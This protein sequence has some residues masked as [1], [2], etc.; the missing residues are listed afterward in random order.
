MSKVIN[1]KTG[2]IGAAAV[3]I[4]IAA[5]V[6][7][8]SFSSAMTLD[9]AK[10]IAKKHVPQTAEFVTSE[11]EDNKYE[12]MFHDNAAK[13]GYEVEVL[14]ETKEVRK[15]ETQLD[16]DSGSKEV[17]LTEADI[18]K[19]IKEKFNGADNVKVSLSKDNGLYEYEASFKGAE[20]YG[21]ADVHPVNG[22]I[23]ESTLKFGTAVTIPTGD[24][25][26]DTAE[27]GM[28][29]EEQAKEAAI[30]AAAGGFVKDIELEKENGKYV[31]DVELIKDN[32]EYDYYIDASTGEV[33]LEFEHDSYFDYDDDDKDDWDEDNDGDGEDD[34]R[35]IAST[36]QTDS[37]PENDI[38][39]EAKVKEIVLAKVPGAKIVY[40]N[41]DREDGVTAY[42]GKATQG[43]FEYEF[44]I[45]AA[46]GV[47]IEW[48][49]DRIDRDDDG[50]YDD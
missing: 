10:E 45:N 46:S 16:N 32:R 23:L 35:D 30:K 24:S 6:F 19:I 37:L 14:K 28:I 36:G 34:D 27:N 40:I 48:D 2:I 44:E 50:E 7:S 49:K 47:I 41:L 4:I 25:N 21:N 12:I 9:E 5:I 11:D 13:E 20:F 26:K 33:T 18:E 22:A 31:Y 17:K 42:E 29:S 43:E 38:I 39:S 8:T 15:V 3:V 1:K